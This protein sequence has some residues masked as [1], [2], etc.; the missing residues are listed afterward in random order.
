[1][2]INFTA[3]QAAWIFLLACGVFAFIKPCPGEYCHL[4]D[5]EPKVRA[6]KAGLFW[7]LFTGFQI[8][9][10]FFGEDL[11]AV[12]I[13][14]NFIFLLACY[15]ISALLQFSIIRLYCLV[16]PTKNYQVSGSVIKAKNADKMSADYYLI[17]LQTT[18]GDHDFYTSRKAVIGDSLNLQLHQTSWGVVYGNRANP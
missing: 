16:A 10:R 8:R 3:K 18:E 9:R 1:M 7:S 14:D 2:K 15:T 4:G 5:V 17:T 11:W 13:G 12:R 6:V